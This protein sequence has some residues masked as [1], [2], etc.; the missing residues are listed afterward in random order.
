MAGMVDTESNR[1][2]GTAG[3]V[4]AGD[5]VVISTLGRA[6]MET[7]EGTAGMVG[8]VGLTDGGH[9]KYDTWQILWVQ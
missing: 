6:C 5:V 7:V 4:I 2:L 8:T 3:M 9:S 1:T